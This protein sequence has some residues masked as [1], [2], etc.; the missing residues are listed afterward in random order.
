[1]TESEMK[2]LLPTGLADLLPPDADHEEAITRCLMDC[3]RDYGYWRVKPPLLEFED[4]LIDGVGAIL[5]NQTF[6][7]MDPESQRMLG[8]RADITPQIARITSSRLAAAPRPLRLCYAGEVLRLKG[9]QMRAERQF[10][11]IGVE[12]IGSAHAATGDAE[13][14]VLAAEALAAVGIDQLS[15]DLNI[16]SLARILCDAMGVAPAILARLQGAIDRKDVAALIELGPADDIA[17]AAQTL[18]RLLEATGPAE[19]G[20]ALLAAL[21]LPGE[22]DALITRLSEVVDLVRANAPTLALTID[23]LESRGF[24]Y[25]TGVSFTLFAVSARGEVGSGGRYKTT[26]GEPATGF[27]LFTDRVLR[28]SP[29][30][31]QTPAVF[32]PFEAPVD[33]AATL[34]GDGRIVIKGLVAADDDAEEARRLGCAY[35]WRNGTLEHME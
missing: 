34:R 8:L 26:G 14:I 35:L 19:E 12:L 9:N 29:D 20:L 32:V 13:V 6:R 28:A 7:L 16:P 2:A 3:F 15:I 17:E 27:T 33:A 25:H 5:A 30:A 11:Q 23:P 10:R 18:A 4:G 22:A 1:M 31:D 24:A 21:E